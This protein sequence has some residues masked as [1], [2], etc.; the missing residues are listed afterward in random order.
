MLKHCL[1]NT[2]I[3]TCIYRLLQT[4]TDGQMASRRVKMRMFRSHRTA[5]VGVGMRRLDLP[6]QRDGR[7]AFSAKKRCVRVCVCVCVRIYACADPPSLHVATPKPAQPTQLA[8]RKHC[9]IL[10]HR[11]T[12]CSVRI[13]WQTR[14]QLEIDQIV[15][16]L[17]LPRR[18]QVCCFSSTLN[19]KPKTQPESGPGRDRPSSP[20]CLDAVNRPGRWAARGIYCVGS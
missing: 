11:D 4:C 8:F 12:Q 3:T 14:Q 18:T 17:Y 5:V 10:Q 9:L 13:M 1:G 7:D 16:G 19:P 20:Q 2:R 15:S 6:R